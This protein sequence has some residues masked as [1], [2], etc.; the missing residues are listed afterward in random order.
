MLS[1]FIALGLTL[2]AGAIMF[3]LLGKNPFEALYYY[4]IEPLSGLW[5]PQE[6]GSCTNW[7]SRRRR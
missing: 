2:V 1:P 6:S 5:N 3:A 4:F 7:R